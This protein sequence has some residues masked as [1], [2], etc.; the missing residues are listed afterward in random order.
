MKYKQSVYQSFTMI[1]QFGIN[2]IVPIAFCTGLGVWLGEKLQISWLAIPL[3]FM[4]ALAGFRNIFIL[5]KKIY[6]AERKDKKDVKK[7]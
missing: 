6:Q 1:M 3:F 4:G 2:M 7:N 5:A